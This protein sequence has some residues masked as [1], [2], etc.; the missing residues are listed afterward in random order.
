M[1]KRTYKD[2]VFINLQERRIQEFRDSGKDLAKF[3]PKCLLH[4]INILAQTLQGL[5]AS[6]VKHSSLILMS[7]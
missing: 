1:N 6:G 5:S 2:I 4:Q 7:S 3:E